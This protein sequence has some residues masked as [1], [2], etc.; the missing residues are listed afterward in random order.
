MLA[1]DAPAGESCPPYLLDDETL[2][3][4]RARRYL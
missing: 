3:V 1:L 4:E 2:A